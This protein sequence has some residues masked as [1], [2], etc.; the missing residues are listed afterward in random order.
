[1]KFSKAKQR[2]P[3]NKIIDGV[4]SRMCSECECWLPADKTH[5]YNAPDGLRRRCL[6][7]D[8]RKAA[9]AKRRRRKNKIK[10]PRDMV[11]PKCNSHGE[12]ILRRWRQDY[13]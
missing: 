13:I 4:V 8:R 9:A 3:D 12:Y 10:K 6:P 2:Y 5:F 11:R 1:M 7:C